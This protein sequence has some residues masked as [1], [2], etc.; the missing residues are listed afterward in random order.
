VAET[1]AYLRALQNVSGAPTSI[2]VSDTTTLY[3]I[4][5]VVTTFTN[6]T[7]GNTSSYYLQDSTGGINIFI[8]GDSSFRPALG[9]VVTATGTLSE[10]FDNLEV[11]VVSGQQYEVYAVETNQNGSPVT[12]ALPAPQLLPWGYAA[13]NP[14]PTAQYLYG[15]LLTMDQCLFHKLRSFYQHNHRVLCHEFFRAVFLA[16]Y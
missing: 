2:T 11:D 6:L 15:S 4:T 5:G 8:T 16:L 13:A 14:G 7:S 12:N 1:I 9:D 3:T 10:Y